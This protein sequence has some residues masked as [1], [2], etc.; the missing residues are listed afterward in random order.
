VR[1]D[2]YVELSVVDNWDAFA[3]TSITEIH[4]RASDGTWTAGAGQTIG[5]KSG[6]TVIKD[7]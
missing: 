6:I 2:V 4:A 7:L 1:L 5:G 3:N